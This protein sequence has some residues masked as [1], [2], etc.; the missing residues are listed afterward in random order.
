MG[1][2]RDDANQSEEERRK[3][4][5]VIGLREINKRMSTEKSEVGRESMV[6]GWMSIQWFLQ[7]INAR[8]TITS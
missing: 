3:G 6:R 5:T 1:S 8:I 2:G 4:A 7:F